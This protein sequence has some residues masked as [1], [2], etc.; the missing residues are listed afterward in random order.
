MTKREI[1]KMVEESIGQEWDRSNLNGVALRRRLIPPE[2][3]NAINVGDEAEP[4]VWLVLLEAPDTRFGY[5]IAYHEQTRQFG[6]VQLTKEYE[7]C[8]L[9]FYGTIFKALEAM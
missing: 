5:A 4:P 9:G 8:L 1:Q 6:L 7:P 2:R 3:V